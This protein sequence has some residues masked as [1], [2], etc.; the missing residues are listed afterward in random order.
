MRRPAPPPCA[1]LPA[2]RAPQFPPPSTPLQPPPLQPY[3][4]KTR[5]ALLPF[6]IANIVVTDLVMAGMIGLRT[7]GAAL[8]TMIAISLVSYLVA[9]QV[10]SLAAIVTPNQEAAFSLAI[11]WTAVCLQLSNYVIRYADMQMAWLSQLR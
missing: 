5:V 11:V 2:A 1:P 8:G 6:V 9:Q 10:L 4:T 7:D 3:Q